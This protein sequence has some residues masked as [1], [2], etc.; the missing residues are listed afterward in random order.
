MDEG[1]K[2]IKTET[3][4]DQAKEALRC[5]KYENVVGLL[6]KSI[7]L[8]D[9]NKDRGY[10]CW[11]FAKAYAQGLWGIKRDTLSEH[12]MLTNG[13]R[14]GDLLSMA[15]MV[16]R[17]YM[18]LGPPLID[19]S[20]MKVLIEK[21]TQSESYHAKVKLCTVQSKYVEAV[22]YLKNAHEDM[23]AKFD[24]YYYWTNFTTETADPQFLFTL[25]MQSAEQ[26]CCEAQWSLVKIEDPR[27]ITKYRRFKWLK[28]ATLQGYINEHFWWNY[29]NFDYETYK[30]LDHCVNAVVCLLCIKKYHKNNCG[31]LCL[32]P[33]DIVKQ[34]AK[35]IYKTQTDIKWE[36]NTL[37]WQKI[38][39]ILSNQ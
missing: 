11:M 21:I 4:L 30:R 32:V 18:T 10:A 15:E 36:I 34:I 7:D 29:K 20:E 22:S 25:L 31:S 2:K 14:F 12:I 39:K 23:Y 24:L 8:D 38:D 33:F 35:C 6:E 27:L 19:T 5:G 9:D 37:E 16:R 28:K 13:V 26:G 3:Y 17:K 1:K